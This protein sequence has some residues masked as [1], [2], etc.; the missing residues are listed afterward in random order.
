MVVTEAGVLLA[1]ILDQ[2]RCTAGQFLRRLAARHEALGLGIMV[3]RPEKFSRW[4]SGT[5]PE[6]RAQIALADLLGVS[7]EQLYALGWPGWLRLALHDG[8]ALLAS[9]WTHAGSVQALH[10]LAHTERL[11]D[12]ERRAVIIAGGTLA[13]TLAGWSAAT[14]AGAMQTPG[15]TPRLTTGSVDLIDSRLDSLRRQDDQVGSE[16]TYALA[17]TE[18]SQLVRSLK[19]ASYNTDTGRRLFAAAAEASRI[20]GWAAFDSGNTGVAERHYLAAL[21]AAASADNPVVTANTLSFWA[22]LRYSANDPAGALQL[23]DAAHHHARKIGSA[24]MTAMLHARASRAHAKAGDQQASRRAEA[25]AFTTYDQ[26]GPADD[27]PPCVY[28]VDRNELHGWAATNALDLNNPRRALTQHTA[29]TA[30]HYTEQHDDQAQPRTAALRLTR[31]ADAYLAL[32][33]V[34][35]AVHTAGRAVQIL[36]GVASSRGTAIFAGLKTKLAA[37]QDVPA[38]RDFLETTR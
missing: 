26:A 36:G 16:H 25:A 24:R 27:E 17:R 31:Q 7:V 13:A 1:R 34:D 21:R 29:I 18:L 3:A 14:P 10:A 22:M 5:I 33:D 15:R 30:A 23:V 9:P 12:M 6:R 20:S 37:H 38:V 28:W 8:H 35:V 4:C 19:T 2:E 32:G 11:A